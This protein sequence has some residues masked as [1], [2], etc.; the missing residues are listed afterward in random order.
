MDDACNRKPFFT[1][2]D[3]VKCH[4]ESEGRFHSGTSTDTQMECV[5]C[6]SWLGSME[7]HRWGWET[8]GTGP[9]CRLDQVLQNMG[10]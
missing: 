4:I 10:R 1:Q 7:L 9:H 2:L 3:W 6:D 5:P 8:S